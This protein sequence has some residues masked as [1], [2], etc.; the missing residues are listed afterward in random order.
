MV[1]LYPLSSG[2]SGNCFYLSAGESLGGLLIDAGISAR[3]I[4]QSL[5][6]ASID[7]AGLRGIL[8]T[9][10]HVDHIAG[11]RVLARQLRLPVYATAGTLQRLAAAV[12]PGTRLI[13][14]QKEQEIAAM[15]VQPFATQ[16]DAPYSCGFRITAG[17]RVIGF[18][19]DL[20]C[21]TPTVWE[22]LLG[23]HLTVLESNYEDSVLLNCGYPYYLKQRIRSEYGHLSNREAAGTVAELARC[24]T[25]HFVL[26]HLS[27]ESNTPA[28]AREGAEGALA[29]ADLLPERDYR[30]WIAPRDCPGA[31]IRF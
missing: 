1:T 28:R 25:A 13:E 19:T 15:G 9:H 27:R 14:L 3:R 20:G 21:V 11:L 17:S 24:G 18:A 23:T 31:M 4:R 30:L 5:W 12:E 6:E 8:I 10:D 22:H 29:A 26:A 2:S 16:H 7:P